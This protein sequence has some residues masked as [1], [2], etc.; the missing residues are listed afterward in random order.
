MRFAAPLLLLTLTGCGLISAYEEGAADRFLTG[1]GAQPVSGPETR[2]EA[3]PSTDEAAEP[4]GASA[5]QQS[6]ADAEGEGGESSEPEARVDDSAEAETAP[7]EK[8][9]GAAPLTSAESL[10]RSVSYASAHGI[11]Q[12]W[13]PRLFQESA[14]SQA[15]PRDPLDLLKRTLDAND[16]PAEAF[17]PAVE[18]AHAD[19]EYASVEASD[20]NGASDGPEAE[21]ALP[22]MDPR[23]DALAEEMGELRTG[24][25]QV[26]D[27]LEYFMDAFFE[28]VHAENQ[29]L[30]QEVQQLHARLPAQEPSHDPG[31]NVPRPSRDMLEEV[32]WDHLERTG[33][34][35]PG[36]LYEAYQE[37][38]RLAAEGGA[39]G[40]AGA[41]QAPPDAA[42]APGTGSPAEAAQA[43]GP[44]E[45]LEM[46]QTD[47]GLQFAVVGEWGRSPEEAGQ[48]GEQVASLKA[49]I[50]ALPEEY[51]NDELVDLGAWFRSQYAEYDN[52]N[53][54]VFSSPQAARQFQEAHVAPEGSRVLAVS[55]HASSGR[56]V[57]LVISGDTVYEYPWDDIS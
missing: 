16:L 57:I 14:T 4:N 30:R 29:R 5:G 56:D 8:V 20:G 21:E 53:V 55:R 39:G 18:P 51:S 32:I 40:P 54:E 27:A 3:A 35:I 9:D 7:L 28:G 43:A 19:E 36:D 26:H 31:P 11:M 23:I 12:P 49:I 17:M 45:E 34:P 41:G 6:S 25:T 24:L 48:L 38:G 50:A 2:A 33:E 52:I 44:A 13:L 22:D 46:V 47:M 1:I 42:D 10:L 15:S 37:Y